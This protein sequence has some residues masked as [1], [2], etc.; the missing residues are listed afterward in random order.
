MSLESM[1]RPYS[2][3]RIVDLAQEL[4]SYLTRL[5]ADLGAEVIRIEPLGGRADRCAGA[6]L[7]PERAAAGGAAFAFL[8]ANKKSVTVDLATDEGRSLLRA[9]VASAQIV[10]YEPDEDRDEMVDLLMGVPGPRVVTVVSWFGLT[11]PYAN[12][13]GCDLVAQSLGGIAYLSGTEAGRPLRIGGGQSAIVASI[14]GAVATAA[15]LVDAERNG[16]RHLLD[17]SAQEAIAHSLQNA[18]PMYDLERVVPR[19]GGDMGPFLQGIFACRD[20]YVLLSAPPFMANQLNALIQW[21]DDEGFG[22]AATL[23]APEWRDAVQ[24]V[25][26]ALRQEFRFI[27]ERFLA[28]RSR[29]TIAAEALA[30][31]ILL[32]PVNRM[33]DLPLDLQLLHRGFFIKVAQRALGRDVLFPGAPY[34]LSEPVWAVE[35]GA[36][37][38]G[39]DQELA[40][41]LV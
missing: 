33:A 29:V 28:G 21:M 19:R 41:A 20:G 2:G 15:A 10:V 16:A 1:T 37:Q 4:G 9:L 18:P 34:R 17:V 36:P 3:I 31:K 13:V 38:L 35:R 7:D 39:E 40:A 12:Y 30:R 14:Y 22:G 24:N 6:P 27:L 25:N 11:G 8:G 26:P 32:A 5:F 23:R